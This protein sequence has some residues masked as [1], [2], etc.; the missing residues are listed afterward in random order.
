MG[1]C[2]GAIHPEPG[3]RREMGLGMQG[4]QEPLAEPQHVQAHRRQQMSQLDPGKTPGTGSS[5]ARATRAVS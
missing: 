2:C 4:L 3:E 5:Q 1:L